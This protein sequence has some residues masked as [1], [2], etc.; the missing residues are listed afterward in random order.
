ML[1]GVYA[2]YL[3]KKNTLLIKGAIIL[4]IRLHLVDSMFDSIRNNSSNNIYK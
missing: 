3:G 4:A 2:D 1:N